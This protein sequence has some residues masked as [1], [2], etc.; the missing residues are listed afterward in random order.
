[1]I[2]LIRASKVTAG[3]MIESVLD[4]GTFVPVRRVSTVRGR[5]RIETFES[6][7]RLKSRAKVR[8]N[9]M[10]NPV[11]ESD[12]FKKVQAWA[13]AV[14]ADETPKK[15]RSMASEAITALVEVSQQLADAPDSAGARTSL[16]RLLKRVVACRDT[17]DIESLMTAVEHWTKRYGHLV[18]F[19]SS[20]ELLRVYGYGHDWENSSI[21]ALK[22][23]KH[24]VGDVDDIDDLPTRV[25]KKLARPSCDNCGAPLRRKGPAL[26]RGWG[27][28]ICDYCGS[29]YSIRER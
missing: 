15:S 24:L 13:A 12:A 6:I 19:R 16:Q 18:P 28:Y 22:K 2:K 7:M 5:R 17:V 3:C 23:L 10:Y 25:G 9:V 21:A 14:L 8:I 1:M 27:L 26:K 29:E 20:R 11:M 4:P